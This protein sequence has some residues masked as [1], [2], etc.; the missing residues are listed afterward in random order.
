MNFIKKLYNEHHY[1]SALIFVLLGLIVMMVLAGCST[2]AASTT[3]P[4]AV[5]AEQP[6]EQ[7]PPP[8][9]E[10]IKQLGDVITYEDG[11]SV[12]VSEPSEFVPSEYAAGNDQANQILMSFT[13]TNGTTEALDPIF[14]VSV[15]SDGV[16]ASQI[17]DVDNPAGEVNFS[18]STAVLP[19][20]TITWMLAFSVAD[21]SKLTVDFSPGFDWDSAIFTNI[22]F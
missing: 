4:S 22:P 15:S 5:S 7:T 10:L 6:T 21:P 8:V 11:L 19:G 14:G 2:G 17:Y 12:S 13:V 3:D 16:E 1:I 9:N 18:P 20:Q